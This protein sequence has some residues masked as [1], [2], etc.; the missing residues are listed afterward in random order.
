MKSGM[1][2]GV[3]ACRA[4]Q[5]CGATLCHTGS[6]RTLQAM[7]TEATQLVPLHERPLHERVAA[8]IRS[9]RATYQVLQADIARAL[10]VSQQTVSEKLGGKVAITLDELGVIAPLFGLEPDDVIRQARSLRP[11]VIA[12]GPRPPTPTLDSGGR[13]LHLLRVRPTGLEPAAFC[14]GGRRSIH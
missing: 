9:E 2:K 13:R 8:V 12:P 5:S 1:R 11:V 3:S 10:G 4:H 7:S 14:S 6:G